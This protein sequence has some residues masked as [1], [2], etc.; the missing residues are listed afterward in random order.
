MPPFPQHCPSA[1]IHSAKQRHEPGIGAQV[2]EKKRAL[3][4]VD[5]TRAPLESALKIVDRRIGLA[6]AGVH[7]G[8]MVRRDE[9]ARRPIAQLLEYLPC[10]FNVA[11]QSV[12]LPKLGEE[13]RFTW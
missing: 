9:F 4:A 6:E 3:D 1:Q 11:C 12:G 8:E 7:I 5:R 2:S 13:Q 10:P